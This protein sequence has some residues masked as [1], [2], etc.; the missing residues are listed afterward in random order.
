M[1]VAVACRHW[2]KTDWDIGQC[3]YF[4]QQSCKER[5]QYFNWAFEHTAHCG[6]PSSGCL[7]FG[8]FFIL[9]QEQEKK[10]DGEHGG[11]D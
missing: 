7:K 6:L 10:P 8:S 9:F 5:C 2:W 4:Q 1:F 11:N 3:A